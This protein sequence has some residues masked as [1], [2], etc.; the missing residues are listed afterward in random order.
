MSELSKEAK[1]YKRKYM[2]EYMR[3][4]RQK[5]PEKIKEINKRFWENRAKQEKC[6]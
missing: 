3:K 2:R 5:N 1:D 6:N 4:Y